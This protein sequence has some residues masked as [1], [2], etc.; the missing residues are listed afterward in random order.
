MA[1]EVRADVVARIAAVTD[2]ARRELDDVVTVYAPTTAELA[3]AK[4]VLE[5]DA[6]DNLEA[7]GVIRRPPALL[8]LDLQMLRR[9]AWQGV[10]LTQLLNLVEP[11]WGPWPYRS[12]GAVVKTLP[13]ETVQQAVRLLHAG[14]L[15]ELCDHDRVGP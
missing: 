4:S 11:R 6:V 9:L 8:D 5:Q 1:E 15:H 14:D 12:L 10:A 7:A 2:A 3:A 13:A